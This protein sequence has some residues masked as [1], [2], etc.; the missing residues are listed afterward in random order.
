MLHGNN[1]PRAQADIW[2][3]LDA[4]V[5][6]E[7]LDT[8]ENRRITTTANLSRSIYVYET[9]DVFDKVIYLDDAPVE[10]TAG[11]WEAADWLD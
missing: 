2:L 3:Y 8:Q 1:M 11:A 4:F 9:P 10:A 6:Q 5:S 7:F